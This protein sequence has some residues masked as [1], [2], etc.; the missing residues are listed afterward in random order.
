[1]A[2]RRTNRLFAG[3]AIAAAALTLAACGSSST[4]GSSSTATPSGSASSSSSTPIAVAYLSAS[5]A[6]TW[7]SS[8]KKA[9]ADVAAKHKVKVTE[10][11]AQC[12]P[13]RQ[14]KH[15]QENIP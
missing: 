14:A 9:V 12:K 7:L 10:V 6:N 5:S 8:S 4:G 11:D 1:M 2:G 15:D 13:G 3:A